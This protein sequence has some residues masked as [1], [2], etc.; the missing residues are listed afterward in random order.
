M[1]DIIVIDKDLRIMQIPPTLKLLGVESDDSVN[2]INFCLP[3]E[4]NGFDLSEFVIRINYM[5]AN[6]EGDVYAVDDAHVQD[7]NV[8]FSWLV[9]RHACEYKGTVK[10]IVCL[11]KVDGNAVVTQEFNTTVQKLPV[12]EGLETSEAVIQENPDI[13]EQLLLQINTAIDDIPTFTV[14]GERLIIS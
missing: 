14:S 8:Y 9:G 6:N 5:N 13:F 2:R 7:D 11:K 1:S 4:Y 3:K 10:F 12:L